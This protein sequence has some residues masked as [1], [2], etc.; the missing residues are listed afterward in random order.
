MKIVLDATTTLEKNAERYFLK[1]K[2]AKK[3][4]EGARKA[5]QL[6]RKEQE[7]TATHLAEEEVRK[8]KQQERKAKEQWYEKFRWFYSSSGVLCV[9]G[10]DATSNEVLIKK[11][12]LPEEYAC[13][14]A[15]AGSPFFVAKTE[16]KLDEHTKRELAQATVSTSRAWKSR[17]QNGESFLVQAKQ[18]SKTPKAGEYIAK[19]SFIVTGKRESISMP[20]EFAVGLTKEEK[21]MGGPPTAVKKHCVD[22]VRIEQADE[23]NSQTAKQLAK[24]FKVSPDEVMRVLPA[25]GCR[26][27]KELA[28]KTRR[29]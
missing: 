21:V 4:L 7:K 26:I 16:D 28:R 27:K 17:Q 3:K 15:M 29:K 6:A 20:L 25:G 24:K 12:A 14:T 23:K 10:R 19:G 5:L 2:K 8:E 18:L 22:M 11:H 13:H 9:G 1:A